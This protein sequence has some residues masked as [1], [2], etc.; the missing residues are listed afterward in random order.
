MTV[1]HS[2]SS[3]FFINPILNYR[4]SLRVGFLYGANICFE[5]MSM[6]PETHSPIKKLNTV[7]NIKQKG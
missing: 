2:L 1:N 3:F 4:H 5:G 6:V 7:L